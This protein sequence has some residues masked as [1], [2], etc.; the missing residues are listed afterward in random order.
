M[1][2][3]ALTGLGIRLVPKCWLICF[4]VMTDKYCPKVTA[5]GIIDLPILGMSRLPIIAVISKWLL[6]PRKTMPDQISCL[7]FV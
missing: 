1:E 3:F 6:P 5:A 4:G 7:F 2:K